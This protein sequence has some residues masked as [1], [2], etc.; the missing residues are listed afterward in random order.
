MNGQEAP[1]SL[2]LGSR[3]VCLRAR[4]GPLLGKSRMPL[5]AAQRALSLQRIDAAPKA[6]P[7]PERPREDEGVLMRPSESQRRQTLGLLRK[8]E[9]GSALP[10]ALTLRETYPTPIR[11]GCPPVLT[12]PVPVASS[13]SQVPS[14][15]QV[16]GFLGDTIGSLMT[17]GDKAP[18]GD[19]ERSG[20][21]PSL[22][23]ADGKADNTLS[24]LM[25]P[26]LTITPEQR[27]AVI[28]LIGAGHSPRDV[29]NPLRMSAEEAWHG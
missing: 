21:I 6:F 8:E 16:Q 22:L 4:R 2:P 23:Q 13:S 27:P 12:T 17:C 24:L 10:Y 5:R 7:N 1:S 11:R 20:A 14:P 18:R 29:P 3:L 25:L 9:G 15:C 26:H 19:R 28:L